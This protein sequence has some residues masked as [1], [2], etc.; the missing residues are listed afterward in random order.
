VRPLKLLLQ[1]FADFDDA[2]D[3]LDTDDSLT[4]CGAATCAGAPVA[5]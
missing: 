3:W 1:L 4:P 5:G 2:L